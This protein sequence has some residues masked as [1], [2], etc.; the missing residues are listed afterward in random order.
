LKPNKNEQKADE[1]TLADHYAA[2]FR[3]ES[4]GK[5]EEDGI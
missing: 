4:E 3:L 5:S 1:G 2:V